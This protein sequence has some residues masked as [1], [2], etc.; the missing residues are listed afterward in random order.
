MFETFGKIE[1]I[2][3]LITQAFEYHQKIMILYFCTR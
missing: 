3:L 1:N 2:A